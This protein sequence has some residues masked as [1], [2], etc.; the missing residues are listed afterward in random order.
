MTRNCPAGIAIVQIVRIT[1]M[2]ILDP[3]G[4][5]TGLD[6]EMWQKITKL[7]RRKAGISATSNR[8]DWINPFVMLRKQDSG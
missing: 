8:T 2:E 5:S 6:A 7:Q 4:D 3:L 1:D